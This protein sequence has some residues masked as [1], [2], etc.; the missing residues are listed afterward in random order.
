MNNKLIKN[1]VGAFEDPETNGELR[2]EM[3]IFSD[4]S[5]IVPRIQLQQGRKYIAWRDNCDSS[6]TDYPLK[7]IELYNNSSLHHSIIDMKA[8]QI[9]SSGLEVVDM[10]DPKAAQ[11]LAFINADNPFDMNCNEV[12]KRLAKDLVLFNGFACQEVYRKD[13]KKIDYVNHLEYHKTRIQTPDN[14]GNIYGYYWAFD[15]T[16]YRPSKDLRFIEKFDKNT[17]ALKRTQYAEIEERVFKE[18][19]NNAYMMLKN[20]VASGNS[21]IYSY[22]AY[23]PGSTYYPLPDYIGLIPTLETDILS[24]VYAQSSLT[25]G[26]DNGIMIT[27][28]G[29]ANDQESQR[30]A[31]RILKSYSGARRAGK[32]VII[33]TEDFE[34]APK[35]ADIGNNNSLAAKYKTINESTQQKILSGHRIPNSAMLGIAVAGKLGNTN[36]LTNSEEVFYNKYIRPRQIIIEKFWNMIME[37]NDLAEVKIINTNVFNEN[38]ID[39]N[40]PNV[41]KTIEDTTPETPDNITATTPVKTP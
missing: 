24:D 20:F 36:D 29:D 4:G 5:R 35:I 22:R 37:Y 41:M 1:K 8:E 18:N 23:Q 11:T 31:K 17:A 38:R 26:M 2:M 32:P 39:N 19:D 12:T 40:N 25:N 7:L 27:I 33:F 14:D 21:Q 6:N 28:L 13:W 3:A 30:S 15:W 9:A 10:N 34:T 16:L